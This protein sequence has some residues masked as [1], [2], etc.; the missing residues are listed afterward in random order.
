MQSKAPF[1]SQLSPL[2]VVGGI[3][4]NIKQFP[5]MVILS[6]NFYQTQDQF[7]VWSYYYLL[8]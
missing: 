2:A 6:H 8:L 7:G 1:E 3:P 4:A 5:H